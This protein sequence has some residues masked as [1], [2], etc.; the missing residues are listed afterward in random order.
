VSHTIR[1]E[2]ARPA[3]AAELTGLAHSAKRHWGYPERWI[4]HW[5]KQL[6]IGPEFV[7]WH[8]TFVAIER[9]R[10]VGCC[11]VRPWRGF[12]DFEHLWVRPDAMGRGVGRALFDHAVKV[13]RRAGFGR[14]R[15][16][17]DPN[18]EGFYRRMG[19]RRVGVSRSRLEGGWRELPV[20]HFAL[21]S[22][23]DSRAVRAPR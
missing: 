22:R 6:T 7:T 1:I 13:A 19:A 4:R 23:R 16:L 12:A 11:A 8:H 9:R 3:Q 18:A 14:M 10:V 5:R 15:I 17:A 2:R 21:A 20:M